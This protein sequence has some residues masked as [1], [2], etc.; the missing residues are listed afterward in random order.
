VQ[1]RE[2][3]TRRTAAFVHQNAKEFRM[4]RWKSTLL[5]LSMV[6]AGIALMAHQAVT[7]TAPRALSVLSTSDGIGYTTPCG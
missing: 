5:V 2:W 4:L 1:N 7:K 6:M 3:F